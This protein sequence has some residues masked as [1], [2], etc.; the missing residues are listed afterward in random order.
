M[1]LE[2]PNGLPM[3]YGKQKAKEAIEK[4]FNPHKYLEF[5]PKFMN[6][7]IEDKKTSTIRR[8][9]SLKEGDTFYVSGNDEKYK[10]YLF[11]VIKINRIRFDEIDNEIA[12]KEGYLHKDLLIDELER[13]YKSL[14]CSDLF[15]QIEFERVKTNE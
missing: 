13:I 11:K 5:Y 1:V 6:M 10:D 14:M 3:N 8:H 15:Y 4:A 9:T 2:Y 12:M 7:L